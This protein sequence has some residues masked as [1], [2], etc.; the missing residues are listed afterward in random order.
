MQ[1]FCVHVYIIAQY[2]TLHC[3]GRLYR[4]TQLVK[5]GSRYLYHYNLDLPSVIYWYNNSFLEYTLRSSKQ[6]SYL[7]LLRFII[8]YLHQLRCIFICN[9]WYV[10]HYVYIY[11]YV[12]IICDTRVIYVINMPRNM[13][14]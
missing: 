8:V 12:A 6:V 14:I 1:Y 11:L 10:R 2:T 3:T 4:L 5:C 9:A 13:H 7:F